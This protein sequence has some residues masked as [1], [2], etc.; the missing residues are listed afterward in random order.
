[1]DSPRFCSIPLWHI[2]AKWL[3]SPY[4]SLYACMNT[5]MT[6]FSFPFMLLLLT[7][8]SDTEDTHFKKIVSCDLLEANFEHMK[9]EKAVYGR[10]TGTVARRV[11]QVLAEFEYCLEVT[12]L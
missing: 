8:C 6:K 1:M 5:N 7:A 3:G 4:H 9:A 11:K 10:T 12:R 2:V